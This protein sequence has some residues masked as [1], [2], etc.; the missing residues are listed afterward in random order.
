MISWIRQAAP[1]TRIY[2]CME[3]DEV[4]QKTMGYLPA[5]FGGL[6]RMLDDSAVRHCGLSLKA[7]S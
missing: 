7:G 5:E 2:F 4:W 6:P 3:D 1:D